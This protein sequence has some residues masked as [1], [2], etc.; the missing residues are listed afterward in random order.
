MW[1]LQK[2]LLDV[3]GQFHSEQLTWVSNSV[4]FSNCILKIINPFTLEDTEAWR[5]TYIDKAHCW[6]R[7]PHEES[8][9]RHERGW[10][11]DQEPHS[12]TYSS[13]ATSTCF[14]QNVR[15]SYRNFVSWSENW[16]EWVRWPLRVLLAPI[17]FYPAWGPES[18]LLLFS[19]RNLWVSLFCFSHPSL[20]SCSCPALFPVTTR[21][22]SR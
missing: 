10:P 21:H 22:N 12:L 7:C 8:G 13:D 18:L 14:F 9:N 2:H 5:E 1:K 19:A 20:L 3:E 11:L 16:N 17:W 4:L 6:G 15:A